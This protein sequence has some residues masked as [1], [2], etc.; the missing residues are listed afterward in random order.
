MDMARQSVTK[1]LEILEAAGLVVTARRGRERLHYLNAAPIHDITERWIDQY[2]RERVRA[3]ADLKDALEIS[4][5][6]SAIVRLP[7][8]H[9][10]DAGTAVAGAD[11]PRVH[12]ASAES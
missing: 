7:D 9:Q 3:L 5:D 6:A 1:H 12:E 8:V 10:D 2:H 4:V 11:Q